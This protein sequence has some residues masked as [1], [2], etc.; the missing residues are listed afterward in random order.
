MNADSAMGAIVSRVLGGI[1]RISE[2]NRPAAG[3]LNHEITPP[4]LH[5]SNAPQFQI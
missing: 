5:V 2:E 3:S 1:P 4:L